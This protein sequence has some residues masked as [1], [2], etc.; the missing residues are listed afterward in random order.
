MCVCVCVYPRFELGPTFVKEACDTH[1]QRKGRSPLTHSAL[2]L[3][4]TMTALI[5]DDQT[6]F[7]L[8]GFQFLGA[9]PTVANDLKQ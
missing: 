9:V 1:V 6:L 3:M 5:H 8:S 7:Y 4:H 2:S